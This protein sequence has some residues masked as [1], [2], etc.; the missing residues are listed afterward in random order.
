[1]VGGPGEI[2]ERC[3]PVFETSAQKIIHAGAL[4][5]GIALKLC[6]NLMTYAAFS[7]IHEAAALARASGLALDLLIEVGRSNGVVTPQM[8]AFVEN[9]SRLSAAGTDVLVK[10]FGPFAELGKKDL[11]AALASAAQLNLRLPLT[12]GL[13]ETIEDAFFDRVS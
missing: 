6:N 12:A 4:G 9:R 10:N 3:R 5:A 11:A 13:V 1:M 7:A 8:Q 2:V